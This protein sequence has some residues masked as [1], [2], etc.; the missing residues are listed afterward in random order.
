MYL[1]LYHLFY[2]FARKYTILKASGMTSPAVF[3]GFT[4]SYIHSINMVILQIV[5]SKIGHVL[6]AGNHGSIK[7]H[8]FKLVVS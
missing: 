6:E 7:V 5:F 2:H 8:M 1:T 3:N 4:I